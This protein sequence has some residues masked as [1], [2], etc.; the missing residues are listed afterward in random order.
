MAYNL[1]FRDISLI[2]LESKYVGIL[3]GI[4]PAA[5]RPKFLNSQPEP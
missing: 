2:P 5:P 3:S 4:C 1:G